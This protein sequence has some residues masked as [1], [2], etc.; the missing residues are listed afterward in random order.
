MQVDVSSMEAA[1]LQLKQLR[2]DAAAGRV[3]GTRAMLKRARRILEDRKVH[4]VVRPVITTTRDDSGEVHSLGLVPTMPLGRAVR[5]I[6][7]H[8]Y[9]GLAAAVVVITHGGGGLQSFSQAGLGF[10]LNVLSY[11]VTI[12]GLVGVA[13]WVRGPA[14]LTRHEKAAG[15]SIERAHALDRSLSVKV[16]EATASFDE[17]ARGR[18][19]SMAQNPT[20]KE[21]AAFCR[22]FNTASARD[23]VV[24]LGQRATVGRRLWKLGRVRFWIHGWKLVHIPCAVLLLVCVGI[25]VVAM[26]VY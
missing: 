25:H 8:L 16:Q 17:S 18:I 12:T 1:E 13:F 9:L 19:A 21:C 5:W 4:R 11:L 10:V 7:A 15:V 2:M 24:L 6:Q 14:W 26:V 20:R 3:P 22:E 23:L